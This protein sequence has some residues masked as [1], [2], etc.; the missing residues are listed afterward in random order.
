MAIALVAINKKK[1]K[2]KVVFTISRQSTKEQTAILT[3]YSGVLY[4]QSV[5]QN[6]TISNPGQ[7]ITQGL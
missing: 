5:Q 2:Y 4:R 7:T 6:V 3:E 1:E